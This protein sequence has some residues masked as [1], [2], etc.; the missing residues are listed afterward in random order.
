MG[1]KDGE[2]FPPNEYKH[3]Q[4]QKWVARQPPEQEQKGENEH[5]DT[6]C[7]KGDVGR[8]KM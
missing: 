8:K 5:G 2:Y 3:Q 1:K 6:F 4:G 7:H